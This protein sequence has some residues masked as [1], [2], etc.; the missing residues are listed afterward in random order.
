M[1]AR[2]PIWACRRPDDRVD[3]LGQGGQVGGFED[4]EQRQVGAEGGADPGGELG[5][6]QGVA[7]EVEEVVGAADLVDAQDGGPD[8]GEGLLGGGAGRGV[9]GGQR[10]AGGVG[11][12]QRAAVELAVGGQREA[13]DHGEQGGDH[14]LGQPGLQGGVN[15]MY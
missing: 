3:G 8:V 13:V 14:V 5:G 10:R 15:I 4:G 11:G 6:E 7:A 12:G 9:G 2:R 1:V